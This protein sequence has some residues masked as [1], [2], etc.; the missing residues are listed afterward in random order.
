MRL[1]AIRRNDEVD[2][3]LHD[4]SP[5]VALESTVYSR[6]GLP[7]PHNRRAL[8]RSIAAIEAAGAVP[9]LT[10]VLEGEPW[11]GGLLV[12]NPVPAADALDQET[13]D[14][15]L[16]DAPAGVVERGIS[17]P[18]VTPFVLDRIVVASGGR[19]V[20]ANL[21]LVENNE[22]LAAQLANALSA[23]SH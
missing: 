13:H 5:I 22:K 15:A 14:R 20:P 2:A 16:S 8:E 7:D 4:Q 19:S 3:A 23:D 21:A 17:G 10:A 11:R 6:L 12:V 9:A 1:T 18:A